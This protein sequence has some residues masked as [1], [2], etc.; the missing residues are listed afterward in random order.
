MDIDNSLNIVITKIISN[1][2]TKQLLLDSKKKKQISIFSIIFIA[3]SVFVN[4]IIAHHISKKLHH[5]NKHIK[6][7]IDN[8]Y[9]KKSKFSCKIKN[10][11][12][13]DIINSF[14]NLE[15]QIIYL[16]EN[17]N[18]DLEQR[19]KK[20]ESQK[21]IL[22]TQNKTILDSIYYAKSIQQA[23]LPSD[24]HNNKVFNNI[25]S[26]YIPKDIISGDFIW[27][28]RIKTSSKDFSY[29]I[30]GDC[31]GHGVP[32]AMISMVAI[33]TINELI[34]HKKR[35][36]PEKIIEKLN[37]KFVELFQRDENQTVM[38]EGVDLGVVLLNNKTNELTY[39][40]ANR[41][42]V[43][44]RDKEL[45]ILKCNKTAVGRITK[46]DYKFDV[47]H[48]IMRP[49]DTFYLFSDGYQDQFGG[50]NNKK[51]KRK[52]LYDLL[53]NISDKSVSYQHD[54]IIKNLVNWK[55][56]NFQVDDISFL[57]VKI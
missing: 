12:V 52:K 34:L 40:G 17:F 36:K 8:K 16:F 14:L 18:N 48:I 23:F 31:T 11:E 22:R 39:S 33:S 35:Y 13:G 10:D 51:F 46:V 56:D 15:T 42:L 6:Q 5:L 2:E 45:S 28:N 3:F 50:E 24:R 27:T 30:L 38:Y 19:T 9:Q 1:I 4:I 49:N 43:I 41:E 20:I 25:F 32:G 57:G 54:E 53:A 55:A 7:F 37:V 21:E 26:V 44:V 29:A 47:Q